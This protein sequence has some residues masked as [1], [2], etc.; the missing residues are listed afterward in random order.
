L[1]H[2]IRIAAA[3]AGLL[4]AAALAHPGH[5]GDMAGHSHWLGAAAL[6]GAAVLAGFL[7]VKNRKKAK[8]EIASE[9]QEGNDPQDA[10]AAR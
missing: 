8:D 10:G 6:F 5:L 9:E 4:P 1:N 7:A 3:G 2:L